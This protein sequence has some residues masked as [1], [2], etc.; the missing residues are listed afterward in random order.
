MN[1]CQ[2]YI[3]MISSMVDG[4]LTAQQEAELRTHIDQCGEC[5]RVHDA[6]VS[7]S[8]VLDDDLVAPPETLAKGI[9][10]KI[11]LQKKGV[12]R[13]AFGRYTAIAACIAL[14]LFGASH[15][16]LLNGLSPYAAA[17]MALSKAADNESLAMDSTLGDA[18]VGD[19][20]TSGT[21]EGN[22]TEEPDQTMLTAGVPAIEN[23]DGSVLL[24]GFASDA[25]TAATNNGEAE[26]EPTFLFDAKEIQVF[27]GKYYTEEENKEKNNLLFALSTEEQLSAFSEFLTALPDESAEY[28]P[29]DAE[30]IDKDP[31]FTLY[32]PADLEKDETAKDKI[33]S[34]W[35][36][37]GKLW[38]VVSDVDA[39]KSA[40]NA[41]NEK[42]LYKAEGLQDKF[43]AF[44]K[45]IDKADD[46]T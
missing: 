18:A 19:G 2:K 34:I 45:K 36:V 16:G 37:E 35:F 13:F 22:G 9:M 27:K 17:L 21:S 4:E 32:V 42:I 8:D 7:I 24:F 12:K 30:I 14:V 46:I 29:E 1:D 33:I 39:P 15:F 5:A 26:K 20:T 11:N 31:M 3:E 10:Y 23:S 6:F 38:C 40:E 25:I 41:I 28:A 43:E 44:I